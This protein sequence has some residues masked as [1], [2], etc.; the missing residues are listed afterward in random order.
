MLYR[1]PDAE[2]T[3]AA[4]SAG[5]ASKAKGTAALRAP[6]AAE[7]GRAGLPAD[8]APHLAVSTGSERR[9]FSLPAPARGEDNSPSDE[10]VR[11]DGGPALAEE[12]ETPTPALASTAASASVSLS[13]RRREALISR[14]VRV[15]CRMGGGAGAD[16]RAESMGTDA[17]VE[18]GGSAEDGRRPER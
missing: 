14:P 9:F 6:L 5:A 3:D 1:E 12:E 15:D 8:D 17:D 2:T 10:S 7:R 16:D 18:A 11:A 13:R 4:N